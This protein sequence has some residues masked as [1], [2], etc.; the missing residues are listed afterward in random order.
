MVDSQTGPERDT[1]R[2]A[3]WSTGD[4]RNEVKTIWYDRNFAGWEHKKAYFWNMKYN[5]DNGCMRYIVIITNSST[6]FNYVI[7]LQ[8]EVLLWINTNCG[9]RLRV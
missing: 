9:Y 2:N 6:V 7:N 3:L 5:A 1:L 8:I 4:T